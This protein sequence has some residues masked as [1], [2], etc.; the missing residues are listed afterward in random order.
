[1]TRGSRG[2]GSDH[3][4]TLGGRVVGG[5]ERS[6]RGERLEVQ[7]TRTRGG[8]GGGGELRLSGPEEDDR[9]LL[10]GVAVG[11]VKVEDGAVTVSDPG[12]VLGAVGF[13]RGGRVD[14]YDGVRGLVSAGQRCLAG[15]SRGRGCDDR[16][17]LGG[18]N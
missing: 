10:A 4:S 17:S 1:M 9:A 14:G 5:G 13:V 18:G 11:N 7:A 2:D 8:V 3:G 15:R 12:V 16:G 6:G